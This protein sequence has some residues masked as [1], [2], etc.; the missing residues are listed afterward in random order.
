MKVR[1]ARFEREFSFRRH[2][3]PSRLWLRYLHICVP[4]QLPP[5]RSIE[6]E[7]VVVMNVVMIMIALIPSLSLV[8]GIMKAIAIRGISA[9]GVAWGGFS[10]RPGGGSGIVRVV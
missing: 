1:D 5:T 8:Q 7:F 2:E 9:T 3:N 10:A 6:T 4:V